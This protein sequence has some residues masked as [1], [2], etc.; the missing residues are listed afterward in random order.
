MEVEVT[1]LAVDVEVADFEMATWLVGGRIFADCSVKH[2][3]TILVVA[4]SAVRLISVV[5]TVGRGLNKEGFRGQMVGV[6]PGIG[7]ASC[8]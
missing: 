5:R 4:L 2:L 6:A 8:L 7:K 1:G 3:A